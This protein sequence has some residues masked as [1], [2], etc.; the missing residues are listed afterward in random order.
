MA[1]L[2]KFCYIRTNGK[3]VTTSVLSKYYNLLNITYLGMISSYL[4]LPNEWRLFFRHLEG[5]WTTNNINMNWD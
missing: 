2:F 3:N 1:L 4:Y 5:Q